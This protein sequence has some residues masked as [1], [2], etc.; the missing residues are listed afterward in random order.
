[1]LWWSHVFSDLHC[2]L[3]SMAEDFSKHSNCTY[4]HWLMLNQWRFGCFCLIVT[5]LWI[6]FVILTL[7]NWTA[8]TLTIE[9]E[10]SPSKI[11]LHGST[12]LCPTYHIFFPTLNGGLSGSWKNCSYRS[13]MVSY[14]FP[15][16]FCFC[17]MFFLYTLLKKFRGKA[18]NYLMLEKMKSCLST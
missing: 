8:S 14:I 6:A 17:F 3:R 2:I 10:M 12:S 4:N 9:I 16:D 5:L 7:L 18:H 11:H 15:E 13:V 1:M